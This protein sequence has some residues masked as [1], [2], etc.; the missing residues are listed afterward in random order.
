MSA[1]TGTTFTVLLAIQLIFLR[2]MRRRTGPE[3]LNP[4]DLVT[5]ARAALAT[6]VLAKTVSNQRLGAHSGRRVAILAGLIGIGTDWIDGTLARRFGST[7]R[8]AIMDIEADS[9]LTLAMAVAAFRWGRLPRYVLIPPLLRYGDLVRTL[10]RG[11]IFTGDDVWWCRASGAVQMLT[12]LVAVSLASRPQDVPLLR[13]ASVVV[14]TLQIAT[15]LLDGRR[16]FRTY[17]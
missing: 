11:A 15:Q 8:G 14:S 7:R 13:G 9:L 4:A 16:R 2:A 17:A 6:G 3:P 10:R 5:G 1:R 12:F